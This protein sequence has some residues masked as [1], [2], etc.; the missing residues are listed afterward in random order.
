MSSLR[1]HA[2][3]I[4]DGLSAVEHRT[5]ESSHVTGDGAGNGPATAHARGPVSSSPSAGEALWDFMHSDGDPGWAPGAD[6]EYHGRHVEMR[7]PGC[8]SIHWQRQYPPLT[9]VRVLAHT[10]FIRRTTRGPHGDEVDESPHVI[11]REA[12]ELW[13]RLLSG[14]AR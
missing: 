3:A 1:R 10:C 13:S 14:R 5:D 4:P 11:A 6:E 2:P 12:G 8:E 9:K 7:R